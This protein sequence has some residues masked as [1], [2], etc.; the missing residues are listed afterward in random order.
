MRHTFFRILL[1]SSLTAA[2]SRGEAA[3][4]RGEA[5]SSRGETATR[6]AKPATTGTAGGT[7]ASSILAD[8]ISE[9]ADRG[10]ILG[11]STARVWLIMASDFQCPFCKQWHDASF[12][13]IVKDYVNK[14]R[15]RLAYLNYPLS[16]HQNAI[17]AAEAAMCASVQSKFWPLHDALFATQAKWETVKN[18]NP[19]FDSLATASGVNMKAY[20]TCVSRHLTLPMIEADRDRAKQSGVNSTPTFF[21]G[22]QVLASATADV[23]AALDE[24]LAK[25]GAAPKKP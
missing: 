11:D 13:G 16:Q 9:R 24:A 3:T 5:A 21:I 6:D 4:S 17:P 22:D 23:R 2:C 15:V 20:R 14:G 19:L 8:T 7:L 1:A 18:P 10:R 25:A 12:A